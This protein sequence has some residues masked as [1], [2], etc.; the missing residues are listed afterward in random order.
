M[1]E[2]GEKRGVQSDPTMSLKN[3]TQS[4]NANNQ[5]DDEIETIDNPERGCGF[6]KD[7]AAYFKSDVAPGGNLPAFVE[8]EDPVVFK[9]DN[10]RS[11]LKFPGNQFELAVTGDGGM[12]ETNPEGEIWEHL[13][14][15]SQDRPTGTTAGEMVEFQ[16][17]DYLLSVGKTYYET[18][19]DFIDEAKVHGVSK[20]ISV[21]SG[22]APPAIN[23]G[24]S[25]LYLIHP[26]AVEVERDVETTGG[27]MKSGD[28]LLS[29]DGEPVEGDVQDPGDDVPVTVHREMDVPGIFGYTYLTRVVYTEDAD[30]NVPAYIQEYDTLGDLDVVKTGR[31]APFSEQSSFNDD[32][33]LDED[34]IMSQLDDAEDEIRD[35]AEN[36]ERLDINERYPEI[37]NRALVEP[38]IENMEKAPLGELAG[39]GL[40]DARRP[41]AGEDHFLEGEGAL[42]VVEIDNVPHKIMPSNIL[43][44]DGESRTATTQLGPYKVVVKSPL[45]GGRA[46]EVVNT[47]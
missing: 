13:D 21:T 16:A 24:R 29:V 44:V 41:P 31:E 39:T 15:L 37:H 10:K 7:G 26:N 28:E 20:G 35:F 36:V 34:E 2:S 18:A 45:D 4:S 33:S 32:G 1:Y 5:P 40:I 11:Y 12:T 38:T 30:G 14:R 8:F 6:L 22:N 43:S 3:Q 42:A 23:P 19:Q 46:V 25:K 17:H 9:E 27:E 47:R